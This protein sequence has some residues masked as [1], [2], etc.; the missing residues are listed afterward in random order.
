MWYPDI[1]IVDRK[2]FLHEVKMTCWNV[3]IVACLYIAIITSIHADCFTCLYA[4]IIA[5]F[6]VNMLNG[7]LVIMIAWLFVY[8][9][10]DFRPAC[11]KT[12]IIK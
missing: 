1:R 5:V 11:R 2:T 3:Y 12:G 8:S 7:K 4:D 6:Y 9:S 10:N